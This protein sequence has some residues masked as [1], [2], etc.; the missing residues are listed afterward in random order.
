MSESF[1]IRVKLK[2]E[3]E[4]IVLK[5]GDLNIKSFLQEGN[6]FLVIFNCEE[7]SRIFILFLF[8]CSGKCF[9]GKR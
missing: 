5:E 8:Y 9:F 2:N 7:N 6:L 3:I 1:V 4:F